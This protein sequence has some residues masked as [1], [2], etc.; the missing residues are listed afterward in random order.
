M[1]LFDSGG[2]D[3]QKFDIIRKLPG[4]LKGKGKGILGGA[5]D[6]LFEG[7]DSGETEASRSLFSGLRRQT[8][9]QFGDALREADSSLIRLGAGSSTA[10]RQSRNRLAESLLGQLATQDAAREEL[11]FNRQLGTAGQ[12]IGGVLGVG[13]A[14]DFI[15][16]PGQQGFGA[17]VLGGLAG[18]FGGSLGEGIGDK[19]GGVLG[20]LF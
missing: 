9:D 11:L 19:I 10:Q 6:R 17:S 13:N 8:I 3:I 14:T 4:F 18:G 5:F 16:S 2:I 20:G 1:G 15:V 12:G 7:I